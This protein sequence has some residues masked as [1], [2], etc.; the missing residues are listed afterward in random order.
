[1]KECDACAALKTICSQ[2]ALVFLDIPYF[3]VYTIASKVNI[4]L[5]RPLANKLQPIFLKKN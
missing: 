1:M 2:L 3:S 4:L 5:I